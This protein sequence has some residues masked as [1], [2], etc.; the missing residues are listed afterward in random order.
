M[1][2]AGSRSGIRCHESSF[3]ASQ[4]SLCLLPSLVSGQGL[5]AAGCLGRSR[6]PWAGVTPGTPQQ[7]P[8]QRSL[9]GRSKQLFLPGSLENSC[10]FVSLR[11]CMAA[12]AKAGAEPLRGA[13]SPALPSRRQI[14]DRQTRPLTQRF[15][16]GIS[17]G[18]MECGNRSPSA[19]ATC[20]ARARPG[21]GALP[22]AAAEP[23]PGP[24][25]R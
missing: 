3:T 19:G 13:S 16:G 5:P 18:L 10:G 25:P 1:Q 6:R 8:E 22:G 20:W 21:E 23:G 11:A 9:S 7:L 24:R 4:A 12:G 17:P 2:S 14:C 15:A